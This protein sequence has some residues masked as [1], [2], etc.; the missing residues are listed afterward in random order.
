MC[1]DLFLGAQYFA[2]G[3]GPGVGLE[4]GRKDHLSPVEGLY[5]PYA[6]REN[7]GFEMAPRRATVGEKD[8]R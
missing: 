1:C 7:S 8:V 6:S 2:F 5:D 3:D 4:M